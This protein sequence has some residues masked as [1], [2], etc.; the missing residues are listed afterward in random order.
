[1]TWN[2][3]LVF[4]FGSPVPGREADALQNFANAQVYFGKLAADGECELD[5]FLWGYG[6]GLMVVKAES[7]ADLYEMLESDDGRKLLATANFTSQ[8]FRYQMA[9][10]GERLAE[11]MTGYASVGGELGYL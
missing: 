2:A 9:Q 3:A 11:A 8:D 5:V 1:M 7:P 4:T 6:G 10:T